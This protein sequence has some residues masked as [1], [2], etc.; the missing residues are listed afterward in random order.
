[1]DFSGL[2]HLWILFSLASA[3]FHASRLA[4]T[5]RLSL[6]FSTEA[7]TLYVNLVSLLL[8]LP[9]VIWHHDFPLHEPGYLVAVVLGGVLSGLGGWSLNAALRRTDVSVVGPVMTLSPG[10]AIVIEWLLTNA[11]PGPFGL[12]GV[13]LL[14][15]GGYILSLGGQGTSWIL[16]FRRLLL[17][18]GSLFA[19]IAAACFAAASVFGRIGIQMSDPL[20]FSVLVAV[21]NPLVLW[22]L[23]TLRDRRFHTRL[24]TPDLRREIR[25]L[26]VLGLLF[27][28]MRIADQIALSL[29]LASYAMAVKR[30]AG[31]FSVLLGRW[32]FDERYVVAKLLGSL[33]MLLGVLALTQH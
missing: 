22:I 15:A 10:F 6:S 4:V 12:L 29:T 7:L 25:P 9:L 32:F 28:L 3:F 20:S 11:L 13:L 23:F 26:L 30:T 8:T 24:I 14:V 19:T 1:M 27:A 21:V 31:V 18:P 2:A 33:V 17:N 16:P 5:K